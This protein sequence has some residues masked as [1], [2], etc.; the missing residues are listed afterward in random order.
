MA[1]KTTTKKAPASKSTAS[2]GDGAKAA[3]AKEGPKSKPA[4]SRPAA[5]AGRPQASPSQAGEG[6]RRFDPG[7]SPKAHEEAQ[8]SKTQVSDLFQKLVDERARVLRGLDKH[9]GEAVTDIDPLADE[10][11]V[12]TRHSEQAY[13]IRFA[14]K[15]RKLLR[16]I[17]HALEKMRS[18]EYGLCEGTEEAIGYPRLALRPWTRYSVR[19]KEELEREKRQR[20]F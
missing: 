5:A 1:K 16:E 20:Q 2:K 10:V 12:A 11:D 19:Y 14:D 7:F 6:A 15:E 4:P 8:L 13:L 3:K 17:D 9:L 18:G